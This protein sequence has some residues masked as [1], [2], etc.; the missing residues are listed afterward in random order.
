M[1]RFTRLLLTHRILSAARVP[2]PRARLEEALECSAASVKRIIRELRDYAGAPVSYDR[3]RNGYYYD[4]RD[5]FLELP[6]LWFS[7]DELVALAALLELLN[8]LAPGLLD[9]NLKPFRRRLE[10]LIQIQELGIAELPRRLRLLTL[11]RRFPPP[12]VFS[13]VANATLQRQRLRVTYWARGHGQV[14]ERDISPQRIV[15]YRNNW[16]LDAWCHTRGGLRI[17]ALERL[18]SVSVLADRARDVPEEQLDAYYA[19]GYGLF[20]GQTVAEA[21]LRFTPFAARW[22]AEETWHPNQAGRWLDDGSYELRLPYSDPTELVMD[23]LRY[24]PDAEVVGPPALRERVRERLADALAL[25]EKR[26]GSGFETASI[27]DMGHP[28][29]H[30]PEDANEST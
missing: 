20:A 9:Q 26:T 11:A 14:T 16:Y 22:V 17:F 21:V 19:S 23:V 7:S 10:H 18:A 27:L 29:S 30:R 25:Y 12:K 28:S 1:D 5:G 4:R 15:H 6:G 24:G 2:V 3:E 13:V 8:G